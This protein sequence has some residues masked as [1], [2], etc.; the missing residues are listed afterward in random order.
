MTTLRTRVLAGGRIEITDPALREGAE[1]VVVVGADGG[2]GAT[3]TAPE[4]A[5]SSA[6]GDAARPRTLVDLIGL[7]PSGRSAEEIDR[8]IRDFRGEDEDAA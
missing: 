6:A 1:V 7:A 8:E 2:D 3:G 4:A 5:V